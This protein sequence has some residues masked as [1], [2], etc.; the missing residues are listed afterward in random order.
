MEKDFFKQV[1]EMVFKFTQ[2]FALKSRRD[3]RMVL[4][5]VS[6]LLVMLAIDF[7]LDSFNLI[8]EIKV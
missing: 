6:T 4:H 2:S 5:M 3:L 1:G 8:A 7:L